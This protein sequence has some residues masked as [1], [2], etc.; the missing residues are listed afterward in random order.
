[1]KFLPWAFVA[2]ALVPGVSLCLRAAEPL[3]AA[4]AQAAMAKATD[5]LRSIS[6]EGGYLWRYSPDLNERA[7][8]R[9][10]TATQIWVQAGTPAVGLAFLRAHEATGDPRYL[11]AALAAADALAT[12]QLESGGWD[13]VI[14]FDPKESPRWYR[15]SDVGKLAPADAARRRNVSTYDDDTTQS[16]L[17]LLLAVADAT[18][19]SA[20]L[21]AARIREARDYGLAKLVAAQRPTGGWPQR[22]DG[23]PAD[24]AA[25]PVQSARIPAVY[26]REH[27]ATNYYGHYTLN[28]QTHRDCVL[29]LFEAARRLGRPEHRA[30]AV[31]GG[32]FLLRAQLPEP[33]PVWAQQYN[34]Q[35][36]PAWARAFEPPAVTSGESAGA[37]RL[38]AEVYL[39]T[40]DAKFLEP[41]PRALAWFRRSEIRPG[42]WARLY[43]L[44]TNVPIYGDRD[45]KIKYRLDDVS[46]ERR[47]GYGWEGEFGV[48]SAI[49]ACEK[50]LAVGRDKTLANRRSSEEKAK[51]PAGRAARAKALEAK[52]RAAVAALDTEGRWLT[53]YRG[54]PAIRTDTFVTHLRLLSDYVEAAK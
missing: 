27:P 33:Q 43:E 26:P 15:R 19:D 54:A 12:G 28:D 34:P 1:M 13:Y 9:P 37:V 10:A 17:R 40:G 8:E 36:E 50:V 31:R 2:A 53:P 18:R 5:F 49:A 32:E 45:G 29:T 51:T 42:A 21:R 38:L 25:Y 24:P 23:K 44:G 7:G 47:T 35:L 22:W 6:T 16:A 39:E 11:D 20:D 30:A 48:P 46:A 4:A 41:L 14:D 3:P 52:A